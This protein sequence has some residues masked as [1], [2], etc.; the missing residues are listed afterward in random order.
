[1]RKVVTGLALLMLSAIP[2]IAGSLPEYGGAPTPLARKHLVNYT[3]FRDAKQT[4]TPKKQHLAL[5][6][7]SLCS[8]AKNQCGDECPECVY[9]PS[10]AAGD[11]FC[12]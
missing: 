3:Q 1:M 8:P 11:Y 5:L 6:C 7:W 10:G 4:Y 9:D 12:E 2:V